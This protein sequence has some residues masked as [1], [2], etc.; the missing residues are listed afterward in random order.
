MR[1]LAILALLLASC[2]SPSTRRS[3]DDLNL[4]RVRSGPVR[5]EPMELAPASTLPESERPARATDY[6]PPPGARRI[7]TFSGPDAPAPRAELELPPA[8][9]RDAL[10]PEAAGRA[11]AGPFVVDSATEADLDGDGVRELLV[12]GRPEALFEREGPARFAILLALEPDGTGWRLRSFARFE[13]RRHGLAGG[14]E[15]W[16]H[17]EWRIA[18]LL[19]RGN[20]D[21]P[22]I[23]EERGVG[24]ARFEG[25]GFERAVRLVDLAT[26]G[27]PAVE[28]LVGSARLGEAGAV[29]LYD[30]AAWAADADGDGSEELIVRGVSS[31]S[32]PCRPGAES[33]FWVEELAPRIVDPAGTVHAA[34]RGGSL[35]LPDGTL[36]PQLLKSHAGI[37]GAAPRF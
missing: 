8:L 26:P 34:A 19:H 24:C 6:P 21:L 27:A 2:A 29:D 28:A 17:G 9:W 5:G 22:A 16:C 31:A 10:P 33:A 23:W 4:D 12:L 32:R 7:A 20:A 35:P 30:G 18:G 15:R 11:L 25:G 13:P 14:P 37:C 1:R 36:P 3:W